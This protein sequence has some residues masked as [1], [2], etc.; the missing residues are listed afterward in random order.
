M[1][2]L[3]VHNASSHQLHL[4]TSCGQYEV[5]IAI[6]LES[7]SELD[8]NG[9]LVK[10]QLA[11]GDRIEAIGVMNIAGGSGGRTSTSLKDK[12][13]KNLAVCFQRAG[14]V[15]WC[16]IKK[17][18]ARFLRR[19][20]NPVL[21]RYRVVADQPQPLLA[22]A[23]VG[24]GAMSVR[25]KLKTFLQPDDTVEA[26]KISQGKNEGSYYI[27]IEQDGESDCFRLFSTVSG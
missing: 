2:I 16:V 17:D 19:T 25:T 9:D 7:A 13:S 3:Q 1:A 22:M 20:D 8:Q 23:F 15:F 14:L 18:G 27:Q 5:L 12:F 10:C 21:A 24:V 26:L 11:V 4:R 6:E